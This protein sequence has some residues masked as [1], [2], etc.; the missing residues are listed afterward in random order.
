MTDDVMEPRDR[1]SFDQPFSMAFQPIVNVRTGRVFAQEALVRG[2]GGESAASVLSSVTEHNR[3]AF[4]QAA[5]ICAINLAHRLAILDGDALLSINVMPSAI[6][7]PRACIQPTLVATERAGIAPARII[8]E[9]TETEKLEPAQMMSI[10]RTYREIGFLTAL[11]DFGAGHSGLLL[12]TQMQPDIVKLDMGL[13]RGIDTDPVKL[14]ALRHIAHL[15]D[16]LGIIT[17]CEGVETKAELEVVRGFGLDLIQG[18]LIARPRFEA[19]ACPDLAEF[20]SQ[21]DD[22]RR[23]LLHDH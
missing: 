15:M 8:F 19:M 17:V 21:G 7:E 5:R 6:R 22:S 14:I 16:D 1:A 9:F 13:I 4:D 18:Y 23:D 11:D 10:L 20:A 12:L 3:Y 2:M